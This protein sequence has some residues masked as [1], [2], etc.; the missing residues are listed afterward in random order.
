MS[1]IGPKYPRVVIATPCRDM[2]I[3]A[4]H[5]AST[6]GMM[7]SRDVGIIDPQILVDDDL[8]RARSRAVRMFLKTGG[9]HLLTWD[10]DVEGSTAALRGMLAENVDCIATTYPKKILGAD[11]RPHEF[12]IHTAGRSVEFN[13]NKAE[14][15]GFGLGFALLSR[16][17]LLGMV[18]CYREELGFFDEEEETVALFALIL[19]EDSM[20]VRRLWPEDYSFCQRVRDAGFTP[21]LYTG[22]GS[23][24]GHVGSL[25]YRGRPEDVHPLIP[26][27][28]SMR[29]PTKAFVKRLADLGDESV[30]ILAERA[31]ATAYGMDAPEDPLRDPLRDEPV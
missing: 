19:G 24:L 30:T 10:S 11:G 6:W 13:G 29:G 9:E 2:Q 14:V 27:P 7:G 8:V 28:A 25:V 31:P 3:S 1:Y 16:R 20:G 17:M 18:E 5:Y 21:W 15:A 12:A 4:I 23:P 22:P 26:P